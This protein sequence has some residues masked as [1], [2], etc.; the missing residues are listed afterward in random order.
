M[1]KLAVIVS[2]GFVDDSKVR[3]GVTPGQPIRYPVE[4]RSRFAPL[5]SEGRWVLKAKYP[6]ELI[7]D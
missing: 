5:K 4:A 2:P 1:K 3:E 6:H 7:R